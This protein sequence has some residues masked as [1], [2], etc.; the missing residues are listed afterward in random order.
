QLRAR[1]LDLRSEA[2]AEEVAALVEL[3]GGQVGH[4]E[5][6]RDVVR[7]AV[8]DD[9]LDLVVSELTSSP[10]PQR[11][12]GCVPH[13]LEAETWRDE[14]SVEFLATMS[15]E[16]E[17]ADLLTEREELVADGHDLFLDQAR[18]LRPEGLDL[19]V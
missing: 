17:P 10:E 8:L 3:R 16:D 15:R 1:A 5:A 9:E 12:D 19:T 14:G 2:H 11:E 18:H 6:A 13:R 4:T 7:G